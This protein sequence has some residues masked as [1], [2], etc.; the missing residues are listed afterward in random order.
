MKILNL[1]SLAKT[2]RTFTLGGE[3]YPVEEMTVENFIETTK[4]ANEIQK[5]GEDATF[6]DQLEATVKMI[7]RSV[8]TCPTE[9]LRR[10]S[11]EQL[12]TVSKFLRGELDDQ[13]EIVTTTDEGGEKK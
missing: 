8:P 5:M 3:E 9:K 7:Q 1:D 10:L 6:S 13:T 12:V 11:I 2:I 4:Q